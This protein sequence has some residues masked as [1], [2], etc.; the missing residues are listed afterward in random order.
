MDF[1]KFSVIVPVY[2]I[3]EYIRECVDS[4]IH[5]TYQNLEIILVNDGSKDDSLAVLNHYASK[6]S[7][8]IIIDKSNGGL[9]S[10]RN[11]GVNVATG[12]YISFIDGDDW[13][14]LNMYQV[15]FEKITQNK[16]PELITFGLIKYWS[17]SKKKSLSYDIDE[18]LYSGVDF[19]SKAFFRV[20]A[21]SKIYRLDVYKARKFTFIEGLIHEDVPFT[22]PFVIESETVLN[23]NES[24]YYYRQQR[25][26]SIMNTI[27]EKK[28]HDYFYINILLYDYAKQKC[29]SVIAL[30]KYLFTQL[31]QSSANIS[32]PKSN[33]IKYYDYFNYNSIIID[34][35]SK[36]DLNFMVRCIV[37][38]SP[39]MLVKYIETKSRFKIMIKYLLSFVSSIM[40]YS[41]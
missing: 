2:N 3:A 12:D 19:Y 21:W 6:D 41:K 13:V 11:A 38:I 14:A 16:Y 29:F 31:I 39:K 32:L 37:F 28:I 10:A 26:C 8:I 15:L 34:L 20:E 30:N 24:F 23:V 1:I 22:I 18:H 36:S 9:S 17:P 33:R 4:I 25:E 40:A 35:A 27:N 5:Q 7:R